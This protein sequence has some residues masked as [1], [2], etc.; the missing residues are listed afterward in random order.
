MNQNATTATRP[1]HRR[2]SPRRALLLLGLVLLLS[3]ACL[4]QSQG[5]LQTLVL[6]FKLGQAVPAGEEL[7][8][9][10]VTYPQEVKLKG[11]FVRVSGRLNPPP[12]AGR[13][14]VR[15]VGT[16]PSG[17]QQH[18]FSTTLAL[19]A[20]GSFSAVK[21]FNKNISAQTVQTITVEPV[22]GELA[23]D[24]EIALCVDVTK[25]KA[26]FTAANSCATGGSTGDEGDSEFAL[27]QV[28]DNEF[29]PKSLTIQPG[30]T[31][32]W[33]LSGTD[34]S[35]TVTA[36]SGAFDSGFAFTSQG[37]FFER[38]FPL[39]EDGETFEY[40]C[41]THKECC[42]MQGSVRVGVDAAPPSDG[43]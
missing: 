37:V 27:V 4:L 20:D 1:L 9:H 33:Q 2:S 5:T 24:T 30:D 8:A 19:A 12:T 13:V 21:K 23:A 42:E 11:Q 28:L 16:A 31:V 35:H 15:A 6:Y 18:R 43:Y 25:K 34:S 29:R 17:A 38:T 41:I 10:Q 14:T 40:S 26:D 3:N 39:S 7:L 22:G 36:M 32:R